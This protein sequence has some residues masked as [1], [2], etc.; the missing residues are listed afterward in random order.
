MATLAQKTTDGS[1]SFVK[2]VARNPRFKEIEYQIEN[3]EEA[4]FLIKKGSNYEQIQ[5]IKSGEKISIISNEIHLINNI[6]YAKV[7]YKTK[8][9]FISLNKIRKPTSG[10]GTS[11]EDEVVDALNDMF[12]QLGMPI[13]IK[14]GNKI[15][16]DMS[17]AIKVDTQIKRT[18]GSKGDP[19][20]DIIIC[21]DQ[22][23]PLS[24]GSIYISHKKEGGPE[25]FQQYG[26][27]T[28]ASG[29]EIYNHPEVQSFLKE[30]SN[31]VND[32]KLSNP[33]MKPVKD[34]KL[35]NMSIYGPDFGT[36]FSLQHAQLIGQGKPILKKIREGMYSLDFTSH[37]SISGDLSHFDGGYKPVFGAT[38]RAGRGF[39]INNKRVDGVRVGIYPMKLIQTRSGLVIL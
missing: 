21:K 22:K 32:N 4:P 15:Y 35:M 2:Y 30:A 29:T 28:E 23:T 39:T 14:I 38:Y 31:Y 11:Y 13:D 5:L 25:A 12:K 19:K 33:L 20:A 7:K 8:E 36:T 9:G 1:D 34:T 24:A 17:Y 18:G 10:N 37:M 26:G 27:L 3:K 16:K 6:K